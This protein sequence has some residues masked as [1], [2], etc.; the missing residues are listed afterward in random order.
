MYNESFNGTQYKLLRRM[1]KEMRAMRKR[2][3]SSCLFL[4]FEFCVYVRYSTFVVVVVAYKF[5]T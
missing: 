2:V 3:R 1:G 4:M 5:I